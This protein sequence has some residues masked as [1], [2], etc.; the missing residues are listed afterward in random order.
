MVLRFLRNCQECYFASEEGRKVQ[1][2]L[3]VSLERRIELCSQFDY[4]CVWEPLSS[5][6]SGEV[7][8]I[9]E[10]PGRKEPLGLLAERRSEENASS[11]ACIIC[12]VE[13]NL[14][15]EMRIGEMRKVKKR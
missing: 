11:R 13:E 7:P 2:Y 3:S 15:R 6:R 5:S 14:V 8:V 4:T 12:S 10:E 9:L 1:R